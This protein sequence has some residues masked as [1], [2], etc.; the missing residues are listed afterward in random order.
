MR[1]RLLDA[2]VDC[3]VKYGYAGTT[4]TRVAQRAGVTRGALVHHFQSKSELLGESVRHLAFRQGQEILSE[5]IALD[6][7]SDADFISRCLDALWRMHQGSMFTAT[8]ELW[9]AARTDAELSAQ[10]DQ[11]EFI[12]MQQFSTLGQSVSQTD[13]ELRV[14]RNITLTAMD[15]VRGILVNSMTA[16]Q[17]VRDQRWARAKAM[18]LNIVES[19][20]VGAPLDSALRTID[21]GKLSLSD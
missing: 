11:F 17:E 20:A 15:A 3:L 18:L 5:L 21:P 13:D 1:G 7:D 2:T 10:M 16:P 19:P 12:V 9:I 8:M 4:T 6:R 14:I